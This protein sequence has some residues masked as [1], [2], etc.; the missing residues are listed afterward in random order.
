MGK[1]T[2]TA[3]H[4]ERKVKYQ[5]M[6]TPTTSERLDKLAQQMEVSR[7]EVLERLLRKLTPSKEKMVLGKYSAS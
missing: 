3:E 2:K 5:F 1:K 7:S 6:L 4:G